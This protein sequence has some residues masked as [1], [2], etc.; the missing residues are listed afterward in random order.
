MQN[1]PLGNTQ[2]QTYQQDESRQHC[3]LPQQQ[4]GTRSPS[5]S[6][7][8]VVLRKTQCRPLLWGQQSP[9]KLHGKVEGKE[10]KHITKKEKGK[11]RALSRGGR[12]LQLDWEGRESRKSLREGMEGTPSPLTDCGPARRPLAGTAERLTRWM[13]TRQGGEWAA[14][15]TQSF[16]LLPTS[17][18]GEPKAGG[19]QLYR[20]V[21]HPQLKV[22][23]LCRC[24]KQ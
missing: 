22:K 23:R 19:I 11:M 8:V 17:S 6:S 24:C 13:G 3:P 7:T 4:E 16:F 10:L 2:S 9:P 21:S 5:P 15:G 14:P 12:L 20:A 1:R 18:L